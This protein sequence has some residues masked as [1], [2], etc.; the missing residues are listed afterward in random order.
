[1]Y[2]R[3]KRYDDAERAALAAYQGYSRSM[4]PEHEFTTGMISQLEKLYAAWDK[5]ERAAEWRARLPQQAAL[6]K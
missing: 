6:T 4:G 5:P 1:M 2:V 3:L